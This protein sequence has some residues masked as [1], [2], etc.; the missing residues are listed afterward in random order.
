MTVSSFVV[1]LMVA[2]FVDAVNT[3]SWREMERVAEVSK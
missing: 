1:T 2:M 3:M